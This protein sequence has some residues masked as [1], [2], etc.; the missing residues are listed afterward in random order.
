MREVARDVAE[1]VVDA[2]RG[3]RHGGHVSLDARHSVLDLPVR[4]PDPERLAW[5]RRLWDGAEHKG[6]LSLAQVFAR[7]AVLLSEYPDTVPVPM[8]AFRIGEMGLAAV[9][10]EVFAETGLAVKQASAL[11]PACVVGLANAYHG[12]LPTPEQHALGGYETWPARSSCLATDAETQI[13]AEAVRLLAEL[14][15]AADG[16]P[17]P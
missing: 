7:E 3:L 13:R 12:Y 1:A 11:Q 2:T 6:R 4:R 5:A 15:R 9:P 8:Q 14:A 10:C 16:A 17:A